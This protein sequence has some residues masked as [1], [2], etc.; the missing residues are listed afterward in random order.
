[1][2]ILVEFD[3]SLYCAEQPLSLMELRIC[4]FDKTC[5]GQFVMFLSLYRLFLMKTVYASTFYVGILINFFRLSFS[6]PRE[7]FFSA[8]E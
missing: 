7:S 5:I 8:H 4:E 2:H 3:P 1:M 6:G